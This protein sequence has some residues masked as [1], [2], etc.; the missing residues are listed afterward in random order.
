M[1]EDLMHLSINAD[2][3]FHILCQPEG[4]NMSWEWNALYQT[5]GNYIQ[6][7][8]HHCLL[9]ILGGWYQIP[10][11]IPH[12]T[13]WLTCSINGVK[14]LIWTTWRSVFVSC[15]FVLTGKAPRRPFTWRKEI[16]R[17][18]CYTR[19]AERIASV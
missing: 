19:Q 3:P 9:F 10:C 17:Q 1:C 4:N 16:L 6:L 13:G 8:S 12:S 7:W 2:D 14:K 5:K 15:I 11:L 18:T